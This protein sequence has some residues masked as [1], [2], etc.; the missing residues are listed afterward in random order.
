MYI[1]C[2]ATV[3]DTNTQYKNKQ[4][5]KDQTVIIYEFQQCNDKF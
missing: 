4:G 5:G 2:V 3:G 1:G